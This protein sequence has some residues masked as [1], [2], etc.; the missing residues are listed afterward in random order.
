[1]NSDVSQVLD[2]INN[3]NVVYNLIPDTRNLVAY[4]EA[5]RKM[6]VIIVKF[7]LI[8]NF[9]C[10]LE[11]SSFLNLNGKIYIS[12]GSSLLTP[13]P[14]SQFLSYDQSSNSVKLLADL[15][16]ARYNHSMIHY[17]NSIYILGGESIKNMEIYDV[18]TK[19]LKAIENNSYEAVDNPIL[20]VHKDFLYSFF[21]KKQGKFVDY[22]Q[23]VNLQSVNL[24]WEKVPYKLE[25]KNV[26][27][28]LTNSAI[29]PFGDKEIFFFGG[30]T[31]NAISKEV[32]SFNFESKEFKTTDIVLDEAHYFNNS[33]FNKIASNVYASFSSN[34]RE[35]FIKV[36]VDLNNK[37]TL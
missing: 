30:K 9:S 35:N 25:N 15:N 5:T 19:T 11:N 28:K 10:F 26:N 27:I 34:E 3:Q 7:P 29:I 22:V 32:I 24:K 12:G 20:Y 18:E 33:Q 8:S 6:S 21:G 4:N 2:R 37:N 36:T 31:E 17:N 14:S 23:R 16:E 13:G 1:M